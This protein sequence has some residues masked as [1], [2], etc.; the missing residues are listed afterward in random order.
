MGN[1]KATIMQLAKGFRGRRKNCFRITV[2]A[3]HRALKYAYVSRR[4]RKRENR[5]TWITQINAGSKEHGLSYG[6]LIYG[7]IHAE[8]GVNRKM[9]AML[10]QQEPQS[11][12]AIVE[13]AKLAL[14]KIVVPP[15]APEISEGPLGSADPEQ[16]SPASMGAVAVAG[17]AGAQTRAPPT[18]LIDLAKEMADQG[19]LSDALDSLSIGE[20]GRRELHS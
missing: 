12:R 17:V 11:F 3:V 4:L 8:I 14:S 7:M 2:H 9:L 5:R 20:G 18:N 1:R 19:E 13:E 6:K 10:A 16:A 15:K